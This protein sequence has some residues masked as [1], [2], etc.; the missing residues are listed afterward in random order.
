MNIE[1]ILYEKYNIQLNSLWMIKT[2]DIIKGYAYWLWAGELFLILGWNNPFFAP[3]SPSSKKL[4]GIW[5]K[6]I[7]KVEDASF[8]YYNGTEKTIINYQQ[9]LE[10]ITECLGD[11]NG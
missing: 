2:I 11:N 7:D 6:D 1:Q 9:T 5:D 4:K 10:I 8:I 3:E